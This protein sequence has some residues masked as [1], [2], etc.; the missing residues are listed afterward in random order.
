VIWRLLCSLGRLAIHG[1]ADELYRLNHTARFVRKENARLLYERDSAIA[2]RNAARI[3]R[4][5]ANDRCG[6]LLDAD[7][8]LV[9]C[10]DSPEGL[11]P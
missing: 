5:A 6:L 7:A 9:R 10:P 4:D 2:E 3:E 1:R 11:E 8:G